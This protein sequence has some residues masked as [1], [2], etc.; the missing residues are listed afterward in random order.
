ML[1]WVIL[2]GGSLLAFGVVVT[3]IQTA[4]ESRRAGKGDRVGR[5]ILIS[6]AIVIG[7][8]VV[9][10]AVVWPRADADTTAGKEK[11]VRET[12]QE[13]LGRPPDEVKLE[14]SSTVKRG[15]S[16]VYV[17][18]ARYGS[19]VWDVVVWFEHKKILMEAA[20]RNK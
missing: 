15:N 10:Y 16:V 3:L 17:G 20:P 9:Q 11:F 14:K 2:V 12:L 8:G 7:V 18:T 19:E 6:T 4:V 5:T 13:R 1:W